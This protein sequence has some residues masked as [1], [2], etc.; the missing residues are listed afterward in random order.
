MSDNTD[1][2]V[3]RRSQRI[4]VRNEQHIQLQTDTKTY[5]LNR[6]K[7][8][9]KKIDSC[10]HSE[11]I[12]HTDKAGN[13]IYTMRTSTYK[14]YS[15]KIIS[16]F[17]ARCTDSD[18]HYKITVTPRHDQN[19]S[20]V[21]HKI[22]VNTKTATNRKG[23]LRYCL[24]L[25]HTRSKFMVNGK[26][27]HLFIVDHNNI[28][29]E[30]RNDPQY[31]TLARTIRQQLEKELQQIADQSSIRTVE[32]SDRT[33]ASNAET[34]RDRTMANSS[35]A[36]T[37]RNELMMQQSDD[38]RQRQPA[39]YSDETRQREPINGHDANND[40]EFVT[41]N[42][43][44]PETVNN[45]TREIEQ[46]RN[47]STRIQLENT[48]RVT[49]QDEMENGRPSNNAGQQEEH[50]TCPTCDGPAGNDT[51]ECSKCLNWLNLN[52]EN[53]DRKEII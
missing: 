36:E 51:I 21:E 37:V 20:L 16:Y 7:T 42:R 5:I 46:S 35:I 24:M 48:N 44:Q 8:V 19:S 14:L 52:C 32:T 41:R 49:V 10:D 29:N 27:P 3:A 22:Q 43:L 2:S 12:H 31:S 17:E 4:A 33:V 47:G 40:T 15:Q 23:S 11:N 25:Y 1:N 18:Y 39:Q 13:H 34:V 38:T 45:T 50:W 6:T 9:K 26:H 53:L 30:V 28:V